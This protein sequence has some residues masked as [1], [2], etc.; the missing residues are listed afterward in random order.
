VSAGPLVDG[1]VSL[2][3]SAN[4]RRMVAEFVGRDTSE[5]YTVSVATHTA[6]LIRVADHAS[7]NADAISHSGNAVL[8]TLDAFENPTAEGKVATIGFSGGHPTVLARHAG[9]ATWNG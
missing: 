4:G 7:I 5:G 3:V 9:L 1:L 2:A 6:R 8:V